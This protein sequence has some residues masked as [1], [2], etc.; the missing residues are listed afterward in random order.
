[1]A[2][3]FVI[4]GITC[5]TGVSYSV[6]QELQN[7]DVVSSISYNRAECPFN[8]GYQMGGASYTIRM[9]NEAGSTENVRILVP[10]TVVANMVGEWRE[11]KKDKDPEEVG[12]VE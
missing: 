2:K 3:K 1:M 6:G 5:V 4:T 9:T 10:M 8:K 7:G 11:D 12:L